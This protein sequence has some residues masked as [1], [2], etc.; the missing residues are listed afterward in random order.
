MLNCWPQNTR[1]LLSSSFMPF[2]CLCLEKGVKSNIGNKFKREN[3]MSPKI[4][5]SKNKKNEKW[6][7]NLAMAGVG[8]VIL[9][10]TLTFLSGFLLTTGSGTSNSKNIMQG[11]FTIIGAFVI[12]ATPSAIIAS[13]V[14]YA[15]NYFANRNKKQ[16]FWTQNAIIFT[17]FAAI[18]GGLALLYLFMA[19]AYGGYGIYCTITDTYCAP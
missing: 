16:K 18:I 19:I 9:T 8:G 13:I 3:N 17:I 5:S 1:L 15:K 6:A 7:R 14:L 12:F 2:F 11:F 4:T 10:Y